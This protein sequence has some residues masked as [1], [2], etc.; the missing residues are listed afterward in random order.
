M[1]GSRCQAGEQRVCISFQHTFEEDLSE[2]LTPLAG[3][4]HVDIRVILAVVE[5]FDAA[6]GSLGLVMSCLA[7]NRVYVLEQCFE[8]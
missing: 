1:S 3:L 2:P 8:G 5:Y 4:L 7:Q 6:G